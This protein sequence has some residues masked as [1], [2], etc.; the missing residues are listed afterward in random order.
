MMNIACVNEAHNMRMIPLDEPTYFK[1]KP[2][3]NDKIQP[4]T[5]KKYYSF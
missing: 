3:T 2:I 4:K 1:T 5:P